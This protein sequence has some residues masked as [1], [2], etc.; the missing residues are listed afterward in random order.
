MRARSSGGIGEG[1]DAV[2]Q[3]KSEPSSKRR[4]VDEEVAGNGDSGGE[5]QEQVIRT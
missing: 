1:E 3:S 2:M 4:K 5:E